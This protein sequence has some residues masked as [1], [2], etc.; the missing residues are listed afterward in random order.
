VELLPKD[1]DL[2]ET[3]K[4]AKRN[5]HARICNGLKRAQEKGYVWNDLD[6]HTIAWS[7]MILLENAAKDDSG[8][9]MDFRQLAKVIGRMV[10]PPEVIKR[11]QSEQ[12][13]EKE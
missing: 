4:E 6:L 1:P 8:Q 5:M 9:S 10:F 7:V 11:L 3:L 2:A 12:E 13:K